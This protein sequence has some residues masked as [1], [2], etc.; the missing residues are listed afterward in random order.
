ME[1]V[2]VKMNSFVKGFGTCV[3]LGLAGAVFYS[4]SGW[5][6]IAATEPD[7][8]AVAWLLH[9]TFEHSVRK[10]S[11]DVEVPA[12]LETP[13]SVKA[14]AKLYSV[15]CAFCHG[16]PGVK[17]TPLAKGLNPAAPPLLAEHRQNLPQ[18]TFWVISNGVRMSG[19]AAM[20]Q[21]LSEAEI[22]TLSAFLHQKQGLSA[23]DY[24]GLVTDN[25]PKSGT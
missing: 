11:A 6:S 4:Y 1:R 15:E 7:N 24:N 23:E 13:A 18:E 8:R 9:N 20:G 22:W 19:M 10:A 3:V 25:A 12:D 2:R 21:S 16:A 5:Q 14:G 17:A